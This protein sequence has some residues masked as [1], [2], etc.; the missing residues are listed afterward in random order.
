MKHHRK[1]STRSYRELVH[2]HLPSMQVTVQETDLCVYAEKIIPEDI[3]E[4]IIEQRGYIEG[5]I[6][7]H[8]DFSQT[9]QPWPDDPLAPLIV[10]EMIQAAQCANV[11]PMA[12]VAGAVAE[13][14]G[15]SILKKTDEVIIEN[16]GD[17]FIHTLQ[18][19]TIGIY[20]GK[21]PLSQKVGLKIEAIDSP[22]SI[23]TSSGTIGH[24]LSGGNADAVCVVSKSCSIADAGAT[25]IGNYVKCTDD[26][27]TAIQYGQTIEG[28]LG[29][30]VIIEDKMGGWGQIELLSMDSSYR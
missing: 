16:G 10:R 13:N 1:N 12:A 20:A 6:H 19:L 4:A 7:L 18:D 21:S 8:P 30:V 15:R 22:I 9:L 26:I 24:S 17:I 5:Y 29:V 28:V 2:G 11:G 25:S 3:K 27:E 23:C 14:V